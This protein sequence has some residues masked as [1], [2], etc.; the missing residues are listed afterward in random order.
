M[1]PVMHAGKSAPLVN[2]MT[3]RCKNITFPQTSFA[4][5]KISIQ[6]VQE[7]GSSPLDLSDPAKMLILK[8]AADHSYDIYSNER[9]DL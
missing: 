3:H 8:N 4:G 7:R 9:W 6:Y 1:W 2:R 5:G